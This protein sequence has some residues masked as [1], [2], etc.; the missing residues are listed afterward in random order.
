MNNDRHQLIPVLNNKKIPVALLPDNFDTNQKK[1]KNLVLVMAG[2]KGT[3][4]KPYTD[5]LP[6][7]LIPYKNKPMIINILDKFKNNDFNNFLISVSQNDKILQSFLS[8][9]DNK[10]NLNYFKEVIN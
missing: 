5:V 6:K 2:G 4:L 8:Q 9:F 1:L 3:R 10:Y 7:P